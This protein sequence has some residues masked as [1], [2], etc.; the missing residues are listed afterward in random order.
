MISSL[1]DLTFSIL[2]LYVFIKD[3]EFPNLAGYIYLSN[4]VISYIDVEN[5]L[6]RV[7]MP[8]TE[9]K[10]DNVAFLTLYRNVVGEGG[11]S[12]PFRSIY[13]WIIRIFN[14][15]IIRVTHLNTFRSI[16]ILIS[17]K[18]NSLTSSLA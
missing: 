4:K 18:N 10:Y 8:L 16:K 1:I 12:L 6:P 13:F 14:Y 3:R 7:K 11:V 2:Y 5:P 17:I 15:L 9:F